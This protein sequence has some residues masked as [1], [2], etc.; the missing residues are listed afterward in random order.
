M[1]S[2]SRLRS[3][4]RNLV[5]RS[6]VDRRVGL[7]LGE[8]ALGVV[9]LFERASVQRHARELDARQLGADADA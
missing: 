7:E 9:G 6:R 2:L 8:G 3:L 4:W 5:H 1:S